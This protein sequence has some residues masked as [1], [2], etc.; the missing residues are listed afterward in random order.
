MSNTSLAGWFNNW[1]TE[2]ADASTDGVEQ[3]PGT[4]QLLAD[5]GANNASNSLKHRKARINNAPIRKIKTNANLG[6][7]ASK[8]RNIRNYIRVPFVLL[9]TDDIYLFKNNHFHL[10]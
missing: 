7:I 9:C 10:G 8:R 2:K 6:L 1:L 4:L 5:E 3:R